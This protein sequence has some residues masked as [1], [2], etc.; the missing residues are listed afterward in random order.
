MAGGT[1][2]PQGPF[3]AEILDQWYRTAATITE[4]GSSHS[5]CFVVMAEGFGEWICFLSLAIFQGHSWM[6]QHP[7]PAAALPS[8]EQ[9]RAFATRRGEIWKCTLPAHMGTRDLPSIRFLVQ[10]EGRLALVAHRL[11][12]VLDDLLEGLIVH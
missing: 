7:R 6:Y 5:P 1:Y 2:G 11:A 10:H 4:D 3:S 9:A 8:P 12:T